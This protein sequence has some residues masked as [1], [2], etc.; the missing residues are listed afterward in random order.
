ML[1]WTF[2]SAN[3][4]NESGWIAGEAIFDPDGPGGVDGSTRAFLLQ[5]I[6]EPSS[7]VFPIVLGA[8]TLRRRGDII[9]R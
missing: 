2:T 3:A 4:I 5:P 6:P 7:I 1:G 9:R 8:L